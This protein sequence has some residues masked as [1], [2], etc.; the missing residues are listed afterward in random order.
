M[1]P[2]IAMKLR[3]ADI[4]KLEGFLDRIEG[5]IYPEPPTEPHVSITDQMIDFLADKYLVP[6][7][8]VLD[9][10][11]GQGQALQRSASKGH[12]PVGINLNPIDLV[13]CRQQGLEVLE[14]DESF[15]DFPHEEFDLVWCRHCLEHSIFPYF[16]LDGF[17]RVLKPQG[18]LYVEVPAPD[19]NCG[20]QANKNHYSVLGKSMWLEL[21]HRVGFTLSEQ[22]DLT[23]T[24]V[25]GPDMYWAFILQKPANS[26]RTDLGESREADAL[27]DVAGTIP[28]SH[29]E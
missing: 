8:K 15:L 13:A 9:I 6:H 22:L 21:M 23:F 16:T 14:M 5:D 24:V 27:V 28:T 26:S 19:T 20:H 11:C 4:Q 2:G 18:Y 17:Y 1:M 25:A 29:E 7:C 12:A 3:T 10:G